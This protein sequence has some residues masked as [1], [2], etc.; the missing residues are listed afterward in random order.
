MRTKALILAAA[1]TAAG[2]ASYAQSNVYSVNVVGYVNVVVPNGY[3][4]LANPL[5]AS[6][7]TVSNL[8]SG[9]PG[10]VGNTVYTWDGAGFVANFYDD[11]AGEWANP[12]LDLSPGTGFFVN[13]PGPA[14]TNTFVGEV[15]QG[16]LTNNVPA[17]YTLTASK[18]PQGGFTQDLGLNAAFGDFI[19]L[20]DGSG[21]VATFYDDL[22]GE[23]TPAA[24]F[25]VDPAKGPQVGVAQSFFYRNVTGAGTW[26][27]SFTVQ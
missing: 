9:S 12:S 14:Y 16:N 1:F 5:K 20:W 17:G 8:F 21:F 10:A 7:N 4:A 13:N 6:D 22:A 11:L 25:T 26:V 23:W 24:G 27:R 15:M 19:Y 18:V 3:S 2:I